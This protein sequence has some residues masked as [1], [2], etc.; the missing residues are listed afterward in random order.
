[1]TEGVLEEYDKDDKVIQ[2]YKEWDYFGYMSLINK[3]YF[4]KN[5][6][7]VKCIEN[8][9]LYALSGERFL[10]IRQRLIKLRLQERFEMINH[11][12]FFKHLDCIAKHLI[13]EELE[14]VEVEEN[15]QILGKNIND[16]S[17]YLINTGSVVCLNGDKEIKTLGINTYV[18]LINILC[19]MNT[20]DVFTKEKSTFY[21]LKEKDLRDILGDNYINDMLFAL[22][23]EYIQSNRQFVDLIN[24]SNKLTNPNDLLFHL[25]N[26]Y[27]CFKEFGIGTKEEIYKLSHEEA[28]SKL[29]DLN[30]KY[31]YYT[32]QCHGCDVFDISD[33]S[34]SISD[35]K[36][37]CDRYPNS[38][39]GGIL[40]TE[41]YASGKGQ[42]W[43]CLLFR[44]STVY[45]MCS[46]AG[47][48]S[49][50]HDQGKLLKQLTQ[51]GFGQKYNSETIQKDG[52]NCGLYSTL[53]NLVSIIQLDKINNKTIG[54]NM[55]G[56]KLIRKHSET[57]VMNTA[58][59]IPK[60]D[61]SEIVK[62]IGINA[63]IM[64]SQGI[65]QLKNKLIGWNLD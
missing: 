26:L 21:K 18:G 55:N 6:G 37:F 3:N 14:F 56:G 43:V 62:Q 34:C 52:S 35:I 11:I 22:F 33:R 27:R 20:M 58:S 4:A 46:Q 45:L 51:F 65:F 24:E 42:H 5:E 59:K 31:P 36:E 60:L 10:I 12:I 25:G 57:V 54:Q 29:D 41:T 49:S 47:D 63:E 38:I 17:V 23:K 19:N 61:I 53:F 32:Y 39:V 13:A 7:N 40:N 8:A 64:H 1:M 2:T 30:E 16:L 9:K 28:V 50:F 44:D 48:F 15:K